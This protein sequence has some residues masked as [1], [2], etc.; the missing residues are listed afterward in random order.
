LAEKYGQ[1][2]LTVR[3]CHVVGQN[4]ISVADEKP[5]EMCS[6]A[7]V[8]LERYVFALSHGVTEFH[9]GYWMKKPGEVVLTCP[10][11]LHPVIFKDEWIEEW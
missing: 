6:G 7:W 9:G 8:A 4:M 2:G 1:P 11:G 3:L 5:I 10:D